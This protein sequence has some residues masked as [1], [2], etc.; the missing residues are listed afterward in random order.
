[1]AVMVVALLPNPRFD[2]QT[3]E[4]L[5]L[6][7]R[8]WGFD[9]TID[10]KLIER[11]DKKLGLVDKV[12]SHRDLAW[13]FP[14]WL[15]ET[16]SPRS[17]LRL[18]HATWLLSQR[19]V[20]APPAHPHESVS[21][22]IKA[23]IL[24]ARQTAHH[25]IYLP[26]RV[27]QPKTWQLQVLDPRLNRPHTCTVLCKLSQHGYLGME[28]VGRD[29][30]GVIPLRGVIRNVRP[31]TVNAKVLKDF[32]KNEELSAINK[33][34]RQFHLVKLLLHFLTRESLIRSLASSLEFSTLQKI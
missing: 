22:N 4:K 26:Q 15:S 20:Q 7:A 11:I 5:T 9:P 8:E 21:Q 27:I 1:M 13:I 24:L 28:I 12:C 14:C 30:Y 17:L 25:V 32:L 23:Q 16:M 10:D 6:H 3:K 33:V 2:G 34:P 18:R 31:N 29:R 19:R